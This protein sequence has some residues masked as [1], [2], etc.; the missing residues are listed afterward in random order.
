MRLSDLVDLCNTFDL[1][2]SCFIEDK[3]RTELSYNVTYTE[4]LLEENRSLR[5]QILRLKE[6]LK[7]KEK[8]SADK[9][10]VSSSGE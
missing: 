2:P 5:Q 4:M 10:V 9:G 1:T 7:A 8:K 6:K 3:N